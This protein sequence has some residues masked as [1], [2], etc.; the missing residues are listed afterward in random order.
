MFYSFG[1]HIDMCVVNGLLDSFFKKHTYKTTSIF[2]LIYLMSL[3]E[4]MFL[5]DRL[6]NVSNSSDEYNNLPN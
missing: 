1:K 3:S 6:S 4:N 5:F 2:D